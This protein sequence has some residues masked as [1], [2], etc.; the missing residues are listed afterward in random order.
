MVR[1]APEGYPFFSIF[2]IATL[3]IWILSP[4]GALIPFT[5]TIFIAYFF[6][7]PERTIPEGEGTFVA[8]ADGKVILIERTREE[9]YLKDE[10]IEI[11]IF[12]SPL[13]V[14]VNRAPC[15]GSVASVAHSPGRFHSAFRHEASIENEHISMILDTRY[16]RVLVCQVA[17]F[18]ARRAVCRVKEGDSLGKGERYGIIKFGSRIDLYLPVIANILVKQGDH[19]KAGET[20][21][22]S[23]GL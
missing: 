17:G 6:R 20:V 13:D 9:R 15:D 11:S 2:L 18:L 12:M 1:F 10:A 5:F 4:W 19:V 8:P 22:A 14:H 23:I 3:F 21:L 7:D 16:G